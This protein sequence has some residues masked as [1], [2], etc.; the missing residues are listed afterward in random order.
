MAPYGHS[1]VASTALP[2]ISF[3]ILM[4]TVFA[5]FLNLVWEL[6]QMP[7]YD[8]A[9]FTINHITYCALGSVADA[10]MVLLLYLGFA[11]IFKTPFWI[12]PLKRQ[13]VISDYAK[14]KCIMARLRK[15]R[16]YKNGIF[17]NIKKSDTVFSTDKSSFEWI[18]FLA[19]LFCTCL[20]K[21]FSLSYIGGQKA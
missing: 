18:W 10:I 14:R 12:H 9:S 15:K 8:S 11:L 19:V 3:S 1:R 2:E 17:N 16:A 21:A 13:R 6:L 20:W 5:F 7:L 4:I